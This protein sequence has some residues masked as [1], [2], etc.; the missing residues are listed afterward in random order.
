M[1]EILM[2]RCS[3][4]PLLALP[5]LLPLG[6]AAA[7][8]R[9]QDLP[10]DFVL[11]TVAGGFFLPIAFDLAWDGTP[12]IATKDGKVWSVDSD[13]GSRVVL[14]LSAEVNG[15]GDRGMVGLALHPDFEVNGWFY[16]VYTVDPIEGE[17]DEAATAASW[18]RLERWTLTRRPGA[19]PADWALDPTSRFV[20]IGET[21]EAGFPSC[22]VTHH[23]GSVRFGPDGAL[24]VSAGE[25]AHFDYY[26]DLGQDLTDD[27]AQCS[28]WFTDDDVGAL[29]SQALWSL[30]GK[31]L[32]LDPE[33]GLGLPDNPHYTGNPSDVASMVWVNGLRN[34][35]RFSIDP[36]DGWVWIGDVGEDRWEELNFAPGGEN[37]GWP[38]YEGISDNPQYLEADAPL[39]GCETIE[40]SLNPGELT[41]PLMAW[42]HYVD[43]LLNPSG[44]SDALFTGATA[45]A[46]PTYIGGLYPEEYVG[47]VFFGDF[48]AGWLR[49]ADVVVAGTGHFAE[50][51][52]LSVDT[53]ATDL[54]G[55]V[56]MGAHPV[57]GDLYLLNIY[58]GG[59][60]R[61]KYDGGGDRAPIPVLEL[62]ASAGAAPFAV[63]AD[64]RRSLDPEGAPLSFTWLWGD[65]ATSTG[66]TA[67]HT[68]TA[69]GTYLLT[70]R[71]SDPTGNVSSTAQRILVDR[72]APTASITAPIDGLRFTLPN[73]FT[74]S[75]VG[76]DAEDAPAALQYRW[77]ID[78]YHNTHYHPSYR[79]LSGATATLP[80]ASI[81]EN[82]FM[83]VN[84]TVT[85]SDGLTATDSVRIYPSNRPPAASVPEGQVGRAGAPMVIPL[86]IVDPEGDTITIEALDLPAGVSLDVAGRRLLWTPT[87][88]QVGTHT[89]RLLVGDRNPAPMT[90]ELV[91]DVEVLPSSS[92][93]LALTMTESWG[94]GYCGDIE[95]TN[96]TGAP[97]RDWAIL[98][99][100]T[101][102]VFA[103]WS[104]EFS[105]VAG[106]YLIEPVWYN[107]ELPP[108][109]TLQVGFCA[110]GP[111]PSS[112][113]LILPD[114]ETGEGADVLISYTEWG[115]WGAASCGDVSIR[116]NEPL[117]IIGWT[118]SFD[119]PITHD[120]SSFWLANITEPLP[121][122]WQASDEGWN[123]WLVEDGGEP[124]VFGICI[125]G[126]A[127]PSNLMWGPM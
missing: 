74:L 59:L 61:L 4:L 123:A 44:V 39:A 114:T 12:F 1:R 54:I 106:G 89:F 90:R 99:G 46:G 16:V 127:Q 109:A 10:D 47:K 20:I 21:P 119:L 112:V 73:T 8:A 52:L 5:L 50:A 104:G 76:A 84:L 110:A 40:T 13:G 35:W 29:R 85:D 71:V 69:G 77:S 37:F 31:V 48:T 93:V 97:V 26:A 14:D 28:A 7:P 62:S 88:A 111:A 18:G 87:T 78:L 103:Y 83:Q 113:E 117:P 56:D 3:V 33:T 81:D 102:D 108:G 22:S 19:A 42:N 17:P 23:V 27:D 15:Q 38:C 79:V 63:S 67:S 101:A 94:G 118:V 126:A 124:Q 68:Y 96:D 70:L 34:P 91:F 43:S 36:V 105:T 2:S 100:L 115:R 6:L 30:G 53:F 92:Q 57:T 122:Q 86:T 55:L 121:G 9:G 125:A 95:W 24:Y 11:E 45:L 120:L 51:E 116:N 98:M 72:S 66:P 60:F 75:G 41:P 80:V 32:R 82:G 49:T 58:N 64:A 107:E 65:G 25:G